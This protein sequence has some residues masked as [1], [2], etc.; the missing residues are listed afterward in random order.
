MKKAKDGKRKERWSDFSEKDIDKI[1]SE[2]CTHCGYRGMLDG[3]ICCDYIIHTGKVR[4]CRPD[5]CDKFFPGNR[6][7]I[8]VRPGNPP[9]SKKV[10]PY[11]RR[12]KST[13][14][15]ATYFGLMIEDYMVSHKLMQRDFAERIGVKED[16]VSGWR[17]GKHYPGSDSI[18]RISVVTG[19]SEEDIRKVIQKGKL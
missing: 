2:K 7:K 15:A 10:V 14:P 5:K 6:R 16:A 3:R 1:I 19:I 4:G 8:C 18:K 13:K 17:I 11:V 12:H 9:N